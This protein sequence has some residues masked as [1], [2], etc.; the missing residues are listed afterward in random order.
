[1]DF[2]KL[3]NSLKVLDL[4]SNSL[5]G[6]IPVQI[7]SLEQL[8][9]LDL[10]KYMQYIMNMILSCFGHDCVPHCPSSYDDGTLR[11]HVVMNTIS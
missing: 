2:L 3:Q 5:S 8:T 6:E 4:S 9:Y 10:C 7:A 11:G 1:M